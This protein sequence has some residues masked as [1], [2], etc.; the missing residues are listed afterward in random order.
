MAK[1]NMSACA[2]GGGYFIRTVNGKQQK[3]ICPNKFLEERLAQ[4]QLR[5]SAGYETQKFQQK[6]K[7]QK[8]ITAAAGAGIPLGTAA[9]GI[10]VLKS[11]AGNM[12]REKKMAIYNKIGQKSPKLAK[13]AWKILKL[14]TI[15][16]AKKYY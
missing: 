6:S 4:R 16:I 15:G 7:R 10:T 14:G 12:S 2:L 1:D 11:V 9:A 5:A 13:M 8:L 3:V